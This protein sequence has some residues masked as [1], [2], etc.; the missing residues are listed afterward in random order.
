MTLALAEALAQELRALADA[1]CA[2]IEV[3]ED[4]AVL[5]GDDPAERRLFRNAQRRLLD[6][7]DGVHC[8]LAIRG[9]NADTAGADTILDAP[10]SSY[11]FDLCA[12][13]DNWRLI[14]DVPPTAA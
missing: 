10:Y 7:M 14:V 1:G 3:V 4:A 5:I 11:L 9:G 8:S 13:P 2:L 6:G 12:G